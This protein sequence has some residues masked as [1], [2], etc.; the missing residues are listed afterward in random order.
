MGTYTGT[1]TVSAAVLNIQNANALSLDGTG[2]SGN[3]ALESVSGANTY[4]G[5]ITLG[6]ASRINNDDMA[7]PLRLATREPLPA[8]L[9][10]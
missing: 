1:T 6:S 5:L 10:P 8:P 9:T 7:T 2:I 3:G 4:G